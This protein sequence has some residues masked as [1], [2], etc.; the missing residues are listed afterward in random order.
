MSRNRRLLIALII[1]VVLILIVPQAVRYVLYANE[2]KQTVKME[3]AYISKAVADEK[4]VSIPTATNTPTVENWD[5]NTDGKMVISISK[6]AVQA[7]DGRVKTWVADAAKRWNK[8]LGSEVVLVNQTLV[9]QSKNTNE[10][11]WPEK[12]PYTVLIGYKQM[13]AVD[14]SEDTSVLATTTEAGNML[15]ISKHASEV[16]L[17][18]R[19]EREDYLSGAILGPVTTKDIKNLHNQEAT[20]TITHELG[21]AFG[22][23][24]QGSSSDLMSP[25]VGANDKTMPTKVE[26]MQVKTIL[27]LAEHPALVQNSEVPW[28]KLFAETYKLV[29]G[30]ELPT[31]LTVVN[32]SQSTE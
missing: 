27:Y 28:Y 7:T 25:V 5:V 2:A 15:W 14:G 6:Q 17:S 24:H 23:K 10:N 13:K 29:N 16:W 30:E 31:N 9:D 12:S 20:H 18:A 21:H 3:K 19:I 4:K 8:A 32:D 11:I 1:L 26:V 22:L